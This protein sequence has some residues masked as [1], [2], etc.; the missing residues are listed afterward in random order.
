MSAE[1]RSPSAKRVPLVSAVLVYCTHYAWG[2]HTMSK[3]RS[4]AASVAD[5]GN[6][7]RKKLLLYAC[8]REYAESFGWASVIAIGLRTL[9]VQLKLRA[10]RL[11]VVPEPAAQRRPLGVLAHQFC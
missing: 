10:A 4:S 7:D 6:L 9:E 2:H 1:Q 5:E 8:G 11:D 3:T